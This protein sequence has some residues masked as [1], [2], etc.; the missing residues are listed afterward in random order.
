VTVHRNQIS[1]E[2]SG[3][4]TTATEPVHAGGVTVTGVRA[5]A[6]T[7]GWAMDLAGQDYCPD[8]SYGG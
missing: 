8:H 4:L 6:L 2:E 3:C 1:C 7:Q 5:W